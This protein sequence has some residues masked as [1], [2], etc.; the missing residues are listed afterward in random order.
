M[1]RPGIELRSPGPLTNSLPTR[2]IGQ[3]IYTVIIIILYFCEVFVP[4]LIF[5]FFFFFF[6]ELGVT[7]V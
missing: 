5:S 7:E 1:T 6:V 4:A 3:H 2:P